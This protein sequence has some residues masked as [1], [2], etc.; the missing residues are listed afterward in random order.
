MYSNNDYRLYHHGILGMRWGK[1]NGPPYPLGSSDHSSSE[2]KAGWRKSLGRGRNEELYGRNNGKKQKRGLSD[3][4]KKAIKIGA[5]TVGTVLAVYGGYKLNKFIK[6]NI[7]TKNLELSSLVGNTFSNRFIDVDARPMVSDFHHLSNALRIG[8]EA[9]GPLA[10][11]VAESIYN[12]KGGQFDQLKKAKLYK[13]IINGKKSLDDAFDYKDVMKQTLTDIDW[14]K[15]QDWLAR[16]LR[17]IN[18]YSALH[19]ADFMR[20]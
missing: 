12:K 10:S 1:L 16:A 11:K 4:Q 14:T 7:D 2:K 19:V 17:D 20:S 18:G 5:A 6:N 15:N 13:D 8:N 9:R 3:K